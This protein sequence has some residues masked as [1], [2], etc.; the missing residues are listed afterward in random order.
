[1]KV[2]RTEQ[3][4]LPPSGNLSYICHLSKNLCNEG[5]Y[6]IRQELE[7]NGKWTRFN[8]LDKVLNGSGSDPS[9]DYKE[10]PASSAQWTLKLLDKSWK[11]FFRAIKDWKKNPTKYKGMPKPPHYKRKDGEHILIFTNQQVKIK[12]GIL[13]F[14][15]KAN[16]EVKTRLPDNTNIREV[17]ILPKGTCYVC[18]IVYEKDVESLNLNPDNIVGIDLGSANIITMVNNIG[19]QPIIIK[20][21]GR[22]IKSINQFFHK[23]KAEIQSIYDLQGIKSGDKLRRLQT[24]RDKKV[25]DYCHQ[26]SRFI[27]NWC[28]DHNIGTIVFGYNEG[29]K[30]RINIGRRNNQTFTQ[31]PFM[32]IIHKTTYKAEEVGVN[33]IE[34]EE[35]HTS[36]C[37]FLDGE[38]IEHHEKYVGKRFK[39]GLFRSAKRIIINSDVNGGYNIAKKAIPKA[40]GK[41]DAGRIGGCG[42]HPLRC[43][44]G[45]TT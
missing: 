35:S 11:A 9:D 36:K 34:H 19:E 25:Q 33:V 7:Q 39:R 17:R 38:S 31:I 32:N 22:G 18:E 27:V 26:I 12:N 14:P 23:R 21:D 10:L 40:F 8:D 41:L 13:I 3:I 43:T 2:K 15:K 45:G 5:N 24:K 1:M 37:S 30:Q 29:W 28:V 4:W 16:M 6:I 44:L 20:D 42:L